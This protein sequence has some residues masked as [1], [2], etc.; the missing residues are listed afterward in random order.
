MSGEQP[1]AGRRLG[2][3]VRVPTNEG[4][5]REVVRQL[6]SVL[7]GRW[8]ICGP[9]EPPCGEASNRLHAALAE[10]FVNMSGTR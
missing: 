1:H 9:L 4:D 6:S 3:K 8:R 7:H 10:D 2:L 5:C